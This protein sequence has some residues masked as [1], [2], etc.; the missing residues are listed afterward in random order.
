VKS[1]FELVALT[2]YRTNQIS[3]FP[4]KSVFGVRGPN[5]PTWCLV[6]LVP[7]RLGVNFAFSCHM[8]Y[9]ISE[10]LKKAKILSC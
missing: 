1:T 4:S 5:P 6:A 8:Q 2:D 7:R 10:L 9:T 3:H